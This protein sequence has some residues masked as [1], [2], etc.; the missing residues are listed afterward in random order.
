MVLVTFVLI[1]QIV[2]KISSIFVTN[3]SRTNAFTPNADRTNF[4]FII[5]HVIRTNAI[6]TIARILEL[7]ITKSQRP[8]AGKTNAIRIN[9]SEHM[10]SYNRYDNN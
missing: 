8:N 10:Q 9:V 5:I 7:F 3:Y 4:Y 1:V 2:I 6:S